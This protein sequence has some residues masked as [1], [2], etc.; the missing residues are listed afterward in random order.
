MAVSSHCTASPTTPTEHAK[1]KCTAHLWQREVLADG[2]I[3]SSTHPEG[4]LGSRRKQ[5]QALTYARLREWCVVKVRGQ[6]D[7]QEHLVMG[8]H[9]GAEG[10]AMLKRVGRAKRRRP[11][12]M[13]ACGGVT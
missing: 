12:R 7:W 13:R 9:L 8:R 11:S 3:S 6:Q 5:A 1:G 2:D 4:A 10:H